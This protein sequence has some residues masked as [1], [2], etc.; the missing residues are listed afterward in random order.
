[1]YSSAVICDYCQKPERPKDAARLAFER[2]LWSESVSVVG[3][4]PDAQS[5]YVGAHLTGIGLEYVPP[6]PGQP[7]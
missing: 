7:A 3:S 5:Q 6:R 2:E 1:M 4:D